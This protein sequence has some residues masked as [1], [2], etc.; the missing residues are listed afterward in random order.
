MFRNIK[1]NYELLNRKLFLI[2]K[3]KIAIVAKLLRNKRNKTKRTCCYRTILI[4]F[5]MVTV[6]KGAGQVA[7]YKCRVHLIYSVQPK[8]RNQN[9]QQHKNGNRN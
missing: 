6:R 4:H 3:F 7:G 5:M 1:C 9:R 2:I 8:A